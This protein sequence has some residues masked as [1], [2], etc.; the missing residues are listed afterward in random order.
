MLVSLDEPQRL[1]Q[2][3][4][5]L[6]GRSGSPAPTLSPGAP[7]GGA[8]A[9]GESPAGPGR[10][11]RRRP[12]PSACVG[13]APWAPWSLEHGHYSQDTPETGGVRSWSMKHLANHMKGTRRGCLETG[14]WS[15]SGSR[16]GSRFKRGRQ[17]GEGPPETLDTG[18]PQGRPDDQKRTECPGLVPP[19]HTHWELHVR[20]PLR[21]HKGVMRGHMQKRECDGFLRIQGRPLPDIRSVPRN[22]LQGLMLLRVVSVFQTPTSTKDQMACLPCL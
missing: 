16:N 4:S 21:S 9:T 13:S 14:V 17:H 1:M 11:Q 5:L 22:C 19:A 20:R 7:A 12:P 10:Q 6:F 2:A 3:R 8:A 18:R 15:A